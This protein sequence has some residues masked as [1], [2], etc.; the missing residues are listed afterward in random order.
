MYDSDYSKQSYIWSR[1]LPYRNIF[2]STNSPTME[3]SFNQ[4]KF[5]LFCI[6]DSMLIPFPEVLRPYNSPQCRR[7]V[8]SKMTTIIP[9][10][11][12]L[13]LHA[14]HPLS[15]LLFTPHALLAFRQ[16]LS[17]AELAARQLIRQL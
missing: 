8:G 11:I 3:V 15:Q 17:M 12:L 2:N 16:L 1:L 14:N 9:K 7:G 5:T 6:I 10:R 4:T 13:L